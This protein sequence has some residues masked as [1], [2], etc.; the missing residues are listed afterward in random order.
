MSENDNPRFYCVRRN[1]WIPVP[2]PTPPGQ[3]RHCLHDDL[4]TSLSLQLKPG[5]KAPGVVQ[6]SCTTSTMGAGWSNPPIVRFS[7]P[8]LTLGTTQIV[9]LECLHTPAAP[10]GAKSHKNWDGDVIHQRL[11]LH[12]P[13]I[14]GEL[15]R[16]IKSSY[17]GYHEARPIFLFQFLAT[18]IQCLQ[19]ITV[20]NTDNHF[21]S[22]CHSPL[23]AS[24]RML[25]CIETQHYNY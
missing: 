3:R 12:P 4:A 20:K 6:T 19:D 2:V 18:K 8:L 22:I 7:I 5:H 1:R 9:W 13:A 24:E 16:Q 17:C 11:W 21:M 23:T 14:V 10:D 15:K 25:D